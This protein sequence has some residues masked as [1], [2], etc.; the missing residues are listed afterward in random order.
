MIEN[1]PT[2]FVVDDDP[3]V[4]K[5]LARLLVSEKLTVATFESPQAFMEQHDPQE[6]GC[7][8][9]DLKMPGLNG[10]ELQD[11]LARRGSLL[12]IIFLTGHADIPSSVRAMKSGAIDF[13]TKPVDKAALLAAI[14]E[15]IER[16]VALRQQNR[17]RAA[18]EAQLGLLTP[19]EREVLRYLLSGKRNKQIAADLGI[20]EK[21]IKVHRA[22]VL[23]KFNV[24]TLGALIRLMADA[25]IDPSLAH[26]DPVDRASLDAALPS[27]YQNGS[28]SMSPE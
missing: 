16:N 5:S 20:V 4:R 23:Q 14:A 19:R 3:S 11:A 17:V 7:L 9:L 26:P 1:R 24:R 6:A 10:I 12:P 15:A 2:V 13:L 8:L 21:T 22:R 18:L 28:R 27:R 25:D